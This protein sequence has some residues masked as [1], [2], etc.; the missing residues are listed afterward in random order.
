MFGKNLT[1]IAV[2]AMLCSTAP[3]YAATWLS[4]SSDAD[5][6]AQN[7]ANPFTSYG[8]ATIQWG[9]S[10]TWEHAVQ[11]AN[12]KVL[13]SGN[14]AWASTNT[15]NPAGSTPLLAYNS[16]GRLTSTFVSGSCANA[17]GLINSCKY[18]RAGTVTK[19]ADTLWIRGVMPTGAYA[20]SV[21]LV[22]LEIKYTGAAWTSLD[23]LDATS[24]GAY[25]GFSDPLL[26]TGFSLRYAFGYFNNLKYS[27]GTYDGGPSI[28]SFDF[29]VGKYATALDPNQ[30]PGTYLGDPGEFADVGEGSMMRAFEDEAA[31]TAAV[32][33]PASWAMLVAGFGVMGGTL[34]RRRAAVA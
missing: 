14:V 33:E 27:G 21:V 32:P 34:R 26:A 25:V 19:G 30:Q 20:T 28:P 6:D 13:Q 9:S 18:A 1:A 4:A 11:D 2:G 12:G 7:S 16:Y 15:L 8:S 31:F 22:G 3:A 24:S 5:F 10:T 17:T 23:F 29:I